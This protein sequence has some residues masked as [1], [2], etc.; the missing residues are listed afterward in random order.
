MPRRDACRGFKGIEIER[1]LVDIGATLAL[2]QHDAIGFRRH[3]R[4]EVAY[5]EPGVER[6][7]AH[8]KLLAAVVLLQHAANDL[9]RAN[10]LVRRDEIFQIEDQAIGRGLAGAFEFP[11][12]VA[13]H[14]QH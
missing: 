2:W 14:K 1:Q 6:I 12:A 7:D 5:R 10:L 11:D 8:V 13:R 3:H 4:G 9:T